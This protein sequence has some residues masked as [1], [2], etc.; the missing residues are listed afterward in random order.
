M[1]VLLNSF[2][3]LCMYMDILVWTKNILKTE[4]FKNVDMTTIV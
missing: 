1:K 3:E 4:L 2:H